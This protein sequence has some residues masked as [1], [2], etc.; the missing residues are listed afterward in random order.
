MELMWYVCALANIL[1]GDASTINS[2]GLITGTCKKGNHNI[3]KNKADL[4]MSHMH[5]YGMQSVK[6]SSHIVTMSLHVPDQGNDKIYAWGRG[7]YQIYSTTSTRVSG[8]HF[9]Q[10]EATVV[11][12]TA[13]KNSRFFIISWLK[14]YICDLLRWSVIENIDIYFNNL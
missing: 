13:W 3:I 6:T 11:H 5:L 9:S 12:N 7:T 8:L 4:I 14:T 10:K 1:L 2:I